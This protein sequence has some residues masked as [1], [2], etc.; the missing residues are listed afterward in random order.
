MQLAFRSLINVF[1]LFFYA[2]FE[3]R[4]GLVG[5][6]RFTMAFWPLSIAFLPFLNLLAR[7]GLEGTWMFN[8]IV[9]LFFAIWS[10]AGLAWS[11]YLVRDLLKHLSNEN[12]KQ[13]SSWGRDYNKQCCTFC[14]GA[15]SREC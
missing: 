5:M 15:L 7:R 8:A 4:L 3:R 9:G 11:E 13:T 10:V 14:R 1:F 6:Y 12:F 2:P